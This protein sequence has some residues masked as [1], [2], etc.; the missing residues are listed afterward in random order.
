VQ[1]VKMWGYLYKSAKPY[2]KTCQQRG[3][4]TEKR[5][6]AFVVTA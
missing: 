6:T 2:D 5:Q 4:N 3:Y 1:A